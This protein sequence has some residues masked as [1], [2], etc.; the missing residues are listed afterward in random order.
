MCH[1]VHVSNQNLENDRLIIE[2]IAIVK[3][4]SLSQNGNLMLINL[5]DSLFV[6]GSIDKEETK[7]LKKRERL[8]E[9]RAERI[10]LHLSKEKRNS[11]Q[12][13]GITEM[14]TQYGTGKRAV[15][16]LS[17][18]LLDDLGMRIPSR[19]LRPSKISRMFDK[20]G[21]KIALEQ[22]ETISCLMF[23][24]RKDE[25]ICS[26]NTT[27]NTLRGSVN[28]DHVTPKSGKAS[29]IAFELYRFLKQKKSEHNFVV[30]GVDGTNV[31]TGKNN[32]AIRLLEL[33]PGRPLQWAIC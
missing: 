16:A 26:T 32:G 11:I 8:L 25:T 29:D 24:G 18:A 2:R 15:W 30:I 12:T 28:Q 22:N 7:N 10:N 3:T 13:L 1:H 31:N 6:S 14:T 27:E 23:G 17:N 9:R 33:K 21:T 19:E 4:R 20:Y 5:R